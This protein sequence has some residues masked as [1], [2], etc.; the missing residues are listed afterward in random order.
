M[1]VTD[2]F[3]VPGVGLMSLWF[4]GD[5][6][7]NDAGHS[8]GVLTSADNGRTWTQ[9]TVEGDLSKADWPTEQCAVHIGGGRILAIAR[10]EVSAS[11]FQLT[12]SDGGRTWRRER[13]N[14]RYVC[15]C[16]PSLVYD[17]A[18]GLV[19]NYYYHRGAK[20]L[21]R[22]VAK[23]DYIFTHPTEWPEPVILAE[24]SEARSFDAGN[25]N[26]T[27]CADRHLLAF[28]TGTPT[29]TTVLVVSAP[30]AGEK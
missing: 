13:T 6:G 21:K 14:I 22:S 3:G 30:A 26:A 23:A 27:R 5:Y 16:T 11:Q 8:W 29:N 10:T 17:P 15:G 4:A 25:V 19:A 28:Y 12:S 20:K 2:V 7:N 1:Q 24:G 18:T 9:R